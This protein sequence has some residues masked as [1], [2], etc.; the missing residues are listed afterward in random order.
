[1][2]I[3]WILKNKFFRSTLL[4]WKWL[5]DLQYSCCTVISMTD[6]LYVPLSKITAFPT[7]F[8]GVWPLTPS[9]QNLPVGLPGLKFT[10]QY[11]SEYWHF[12]NNFF[13]IF[14]C[15]GCMALALCLP[16]FSQ[17]RKSALQF[18]AKYLEKYV[19]NVSNVSEGYSLW[20]PLVAARA[21]VRFK[22]QGTLVSRA[23]NKP[24]Y[25][26]GNRKKSNLCSPTK[27]A[28]PNALN[29][30]DWR[31]SRGAVAP[32]GTTALVGPQ[33]FLPMPHSA[34]N[35]FML[36]WVMRTLCIVW[37][38]LVAFSKTLDRL[39]EESLKQPP[40]EVFDILGKLGE[41]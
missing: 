37:L 10:W 23:P 13:K 32:M 24:E 28:L 14:S 41:G 36:W 31:L 34:S 27:R 11:L 29:F 30:S 22:Y 19:R 7:L 33:G 17:S 6:I 21:V 35:V 15:Y 3:S 20:P 40:D 16:Y 26:T 9:F 2:K 12:F 8:F 4:F 39:S 18:P 1:M 25:K 5:L 38:F